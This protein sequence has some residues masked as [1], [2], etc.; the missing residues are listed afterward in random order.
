MSAPGLQ[1]QQ[2]ENLD[3]GFL[4]ARAAEIIDKRLA[5]A[6]LDQQESETLERAQEFLLNVVEGVSL[7]SGA[8]FHGHSSRVVTALRYAANPVSTLQEVISN[9]EEFADYFQ[10]MA[11]SLVDP[12]A[13]TEKLES[14]R[15]FF[16][17]MLRSLHRA[18]N[19]ARPP[20]IGSLD[21]PISELN[22]I[23]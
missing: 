22:Q 4:A 8:K 19:R 7:V 12:A 6:P 18:M 13:D 2:A 3:Y 1:M 17:A 20:S 21:T 9:D 23:G 15:N 16:H 14:A 11:E 5:G 10:S